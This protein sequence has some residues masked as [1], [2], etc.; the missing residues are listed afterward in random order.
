M[1]ETD[2]QHWGCSVITVVIRLQVTNSGQFCLHRLYIVLIRMMMP[3]PAWPSQSEHK[4]L[5]M[6][7]WGKFTFA[8]PKDWKPLPLTVP[9]SLQSLML[10]ASHNMAT[11]FLFSC[12]I[13]LDTWES[14]VWM[15]ILSFRNFKKIWNFSAMFI[16]TIRQQVIRFFCPS[17]INWRRR[18]STCKHITYIHIPM[19]KWNVLTCNRSFMI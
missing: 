16:V 6:C 1:T 13:A 17:I 7:C 14:Q 9:F 11:S 8:I 3:Q 15:L 18:K 12:K 2:F 19:I 4:Y 10:H 5:I